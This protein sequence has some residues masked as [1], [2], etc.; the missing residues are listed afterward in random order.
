MEHF[1]R[2]LKRDEKYFMH[3]KKVVM[4]INESFFLNIKDVI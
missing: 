3:I 1:L 2:L 4:D